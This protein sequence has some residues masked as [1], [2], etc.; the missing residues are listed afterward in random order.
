MNILIITSFYKH[1]KIE[2]KLFYILVEKKKETVTDIS[3]QGGQKKKI[4]NFMISS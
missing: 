1:T 4:G 2:N 3:K